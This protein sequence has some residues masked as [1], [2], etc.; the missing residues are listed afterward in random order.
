MGAPGI[1]F[2][3]DTDMGRFMQGFR[4]RR[5]RAERYRGQEGV[6]S[7]TASGELL[8]LG[9]EVRFGPGWG[10]HGPRRIAGWGKEGTQVSKYPSAQVP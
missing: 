6:E 1:W 8:E 7:S 3:Q 4:R 5:S 2:C 9:C 10:L